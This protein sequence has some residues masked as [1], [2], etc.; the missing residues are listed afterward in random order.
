M[1]EWGKVS[2]FSYQKK[3]FKTQNIRKWQAKTLHVFL[4][5]RFKCLLKYITFWTLGSGLWENFPNNMSIT[6]LLWSQ[7]CE[8][9]VSNSCS[10]GGDMAQQIGKDLDFSKYKIFFKNKGKITYRGI[11]TELNYRSKCIVFFTS[12]FKCKPFYTYFIDQSSNSLK[13][14][15]STKCCCVY[16]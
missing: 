10:I 9:I 15:L 1:K 16:F 11:Q 12:W 8:Q 7:Q 6:S 4:S 13:T 2:K 3:F 5:V 14:A